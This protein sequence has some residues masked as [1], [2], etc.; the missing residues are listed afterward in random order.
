MENWNSKDF[1]D[2][3]IL[4]RTAEFAVHILSQIAAGS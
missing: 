1:S 2:C 4:S 3:F